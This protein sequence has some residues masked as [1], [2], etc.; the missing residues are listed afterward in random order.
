MR[1]MSLTLAV[2]SLASLACLGGGEPLSEEEQMRRALDALEQGMEEVAEEAAP[3]AD[4]E[5]AAHDPGPL[6]S[7]YDGM[8]R[9]PADCFQMGST[10]GDADEK[11][12]HRVCVGEFWMD[13]HEVVNDDYIAFAKGNAGVPANCCDASFTTWED[14]AP[15]PGWGD[16]P[17]TNVT[18][19]NAHA[20]CV[21]RGKRLPTEAEWE[22]AARGGLKQKAW[23]LGDSPPSKSSASYGIRFDALPAAGSTQANG[24]GLYDMAGS[25][26]EWVGDRYQADYYSRSP[27][28]EPA[29]P[30][31]DTCC[32]VRGGSWFNKDAKDLRAANRFHMPDSPVKGL[33]SVG[34]RC[35]K[36]GDELP[37]RYPVGEAGA[38]LLRVAIEGGGFLYEGEDGQ[39]AIAGPFQSARGFSDVERVAWVSQNTGKWSLIDTNGSVLALDVAEQAQPFAQGY[40]RIGTFK[41]GSFL[42]GFVDR[43]GRVV[44]EPQFIGLLDFAPSGVAPARMEDNWGFIRPDGSWAVP[45]RFPAVGIGSNGD[46]V[47]MTEANSRSWEYVNARGERT[48]PGWPR[49]PGDKASWKVPPADCPDLATYFG[50]TVGQSENVVLTRDSRDGEMFSQYTVKMYGSVYAVDDE[51]WE[52]GGTTWHLP[53]YTSTQA[54]QLAER[55]TEAGKRATAGNCDPDTCSVEPSDGGMAYHLEFAEAGATSTE[56][57]DQ[58]DFMVIRTTYGM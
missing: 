37:A 35:V 58:G 27:Q 11:P 24:Y 13:T 14:G 48:A 4:A 40:S 15:K 42:S 28:Q 41:H 39:V 29:G 55:C 7:P 16:K 10:K 49:P 54:I 30:F 3:D 1:P 22:L 36:T 47:V 56:V 31:S 19:S 51:G 2:V 33:R 12:V 20:Y 32:V 5:E 23:P 46:F 45:P 52:W 18:W 38:G 44:V 25:V 26:W 34:F 50:T 57:D 17:V 21:G 9:I 8:V 6:P 53:G 43:R